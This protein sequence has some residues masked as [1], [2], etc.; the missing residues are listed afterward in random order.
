MSKT[1]PQVW[2]HP[3]LGQR[4]LV[5]SQANADEASAYGFIFLKESFA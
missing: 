2:Y 5:V 1:F 4:V 3:Q